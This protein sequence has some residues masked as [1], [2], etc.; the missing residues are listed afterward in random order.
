MAVSLGITVMHRA[1]A[2][3]QY[4]H[5]STDRQSA[6]NNEM[7]VMMMIMVMVTMMM[8]TMIMTAVVV[9]VRRHGDASLSLSNNINIPIQSHATYHATRH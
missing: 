3:K 1:I 9:C 4:K 8:V 6:N 5:P 7:V 2:L